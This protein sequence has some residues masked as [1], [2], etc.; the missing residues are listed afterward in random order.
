LRENW[1]SDLERFPGELAVPRFLDE[2]NIVIEQAFGQSKKFAKI[3]YPLTY[4][5]VIVFRG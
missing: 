1:V 2:A 4:P 3:F 5:H